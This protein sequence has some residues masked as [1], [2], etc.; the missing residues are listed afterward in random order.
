[1][2]EKLVFIWQKNSYEGGTNESGLFRVSAGLLYPDFLTF[3]LRQRAAP[4]VIEH[5][6]HTLEVVDFICYRAENAYIMMSNKVDW[7]SSVLKERKI[8]SHPGT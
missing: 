3:R 6:R 1:M 5:P 2:T 4:H 7:R 8:G